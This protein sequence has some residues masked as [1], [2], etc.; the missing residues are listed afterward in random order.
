MPKTAGTK[1]IKIEKFDMKN[2]LNDA[3]VL[4]LGR[5]RSGKS[6]LM[7]DIFY[8]KRNIPMPLVFSGT[9]D[10]SPFF[11]DFVPDSFIYSKY[12]SDVVAKFLTR[13][14]KKIKKAKEQ[15]L[16]PDG[17]INTNN[18]ILAMDDLLHEASEWKRDTGTKEL[19]FNGRH[20]NTLFILALQYVYGIP[21]EFRNN[22][23]Y[24]FIF[25]DPSPKNRRKLYDDFGNT[26]E[27]FKEFCDIL[28]QCTQHHGCLV[29][30]LSKN[31]IYWYKADPH[32][33]FKVGSPK[34]WRYHKDNYDK[35]YQDNI[36]EVYK[37]KLTVYVNKQD[38]VVDYHT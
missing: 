11:G 38:E 33:N 34:L 23:D 13:Q 37:K 18:A 20:Y 24:V 17:K 14:S 29:L 3:T 21:P 12:E 26:I 6:W 28:D 31:N 9:E 5:R 19:V 7:R 22:L 1:R 2:L 32:Y 27:T 10:A 16:S 36:L 30:E 25:A 8:H 15:G 35:H 4:V